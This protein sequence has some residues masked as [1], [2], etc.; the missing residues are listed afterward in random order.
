M[1]TDKS[2]GVLD[3][4]SLLLAVVPVEGDNFLLHDGSTMSKEEVFKYIQKI[5]EISG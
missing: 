3:I 5:F 4:I 1:M 2:K